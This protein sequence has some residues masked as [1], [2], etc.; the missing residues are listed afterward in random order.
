M[1]SYLIILIAI[2][3]G[4]ITGFTHW[5]ILLKAADVVSTLFMNFLRFIA[6]PIVFLSIFSTLLGM[7]G[8][9]EM[10]TLGRRVFTYTILTTVIAASTALALFL[11]IDPANSFDLWRRMGRLF[12][13]AS[14]IYFV[15]HQ[16]HPLKLSPGLSRK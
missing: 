8:F 4:L 1:K 10:R 15:L 6:A 14:L 3:L 2:A 9:G 11:L 12:D 13:P 7:S 16:Y 5:E